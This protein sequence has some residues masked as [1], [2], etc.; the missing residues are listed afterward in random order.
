MQH[1]PLIG[2]SKGIIRNSQAI[3][4]RDTST[5]SFVEP[6]VQASKERSD[7]MDS[8]YEVFK[9][10]GSKYLF[11][12]IV[13]N[14]SMF[15]RLGHQAETLVIQGCSGADDCCSHRQWLLVPIGRF[16]LRSLLQ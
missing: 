9:V 1:M 10:Q 16:I 4:P 6:L 7:T 11:N 8:E 15:V 12:V 3:N 5:S 13:C 2:D 14:D